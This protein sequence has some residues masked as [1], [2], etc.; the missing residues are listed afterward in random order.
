MHTNRWQEFRIKIIADNILKPGYYDTMLNVLF[1]QCPSATYLE[2]N[3]NGHA[4]LCGFHH[5]PWSL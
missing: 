2:D 3:G 4:M 1:I 5:T